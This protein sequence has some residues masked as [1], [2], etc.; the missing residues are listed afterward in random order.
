MNPFWNL[1]ISPRGPGA[2]SRQGGGRERGLAL[3]A[4]GLPAADAAGGREQAVDERED[5]CGRLGEER[6]ELDGRDGLGRDDELCLAALACGDDLARGPLAL[7]VGDSERV[8]DGEPGVL[9]AVPS[10][11]GRVA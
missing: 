1:V 9:G 3:L 8:A 2:Q 6:A 10:L 11:E 5:V 7:Y 4:F